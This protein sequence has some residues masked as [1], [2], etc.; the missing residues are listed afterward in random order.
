MEMWSASLLD[1]WWLKTCC[2]CAAKPVYQGVRVKVTVKE[3]LERKRAREADKKRLRMVSPPCLDLQE[4]CAPAFPSPSGAYVDPPAAIQQPAPASCGAPA[5][6]PP[7]AHYAAPDGVQAQPGGFDCLQAQFGDGMMPGFGYSDNKNTTSSSNSSSNSSGGFSYS[8]PLPPL[9]ASPQPWSHELSPHAD[10]CGMGS[11]S[12]D[13]SLAP[14]NHWDYYSPS[15][16]DSFSSSSSSSSSC[17]SSPTR[18]ESSQQ[19]GFMSEPF[20]RQQCSP[21]AGYPAAHFW[22]RQLESFTAA[23]YPAYDPPDYEWACA[24]KE[25]NENSF[26]REFAAASSMCYNIL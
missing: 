26:R 21:Q 24:M 17:Y 16:Q 10:Y 12:S 11:Y 18:L 8:P 22:P 4:L 7:V 19:L 25:L 6:P 2:V 14:Y 13:E 20:H 15:P 1:V 9:T 23:D 3:M 5:L